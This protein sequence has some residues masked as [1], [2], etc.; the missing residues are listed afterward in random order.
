MKNKMKIISIA[1]AAAIMLS[2]IPGTALASAGQYVSFLV[3][4]TLVYDTVYDFT[5]GLARVSRDNKYGYADKTGNIVI[6]LDYEWAT[7]FNDGIAWVM[8]DEKWGIIDKTGKQIVGY[9]YDGY[10]GFNN[11]LCVVMKGSWYDGDALYGAIDKTGKVVIPVEYEWINWFSSSGVTVARKNG[12]EGVIDTTGKVIVPFEYDWIEF[13]YD[14]FEFL[15]AVKN[16]KYGTIDGTGKEII[17]FAYEYISWFSEDG[18][19]V[20]QLGEY[21]TAKYGIIDKTG[22]ITVWLDGY[23][24]IGNNLSE[25]LLAVGNDDDKYGFINTSGQVVI[26]PQYS[27]ISWFSDGYAR[28]ATGD[29]WPFKWGIIDKTGKEIIPLIYD[30]IYGFYYGNELA[31]VELDG[32][33]GLLNK[34]GTLVLPAIYEW[35][36]LYHDFGT[37]FIDEKHGLI[38]KAGK[39]IIQPEYEWIDGWNNV[40][41]VIIMGKDKKSGLMEYATGKV[42]MQPGIYDYLWWIG[43]SFAVGVTGQWPNDKYGM[44]NKAGETVLP[45]EYDYIGYFSEDLAWVQKDG[46]WGIIQPSNTPLAAGPLDGAANWALRDLEPALAA[47]LLLESMYGKWAQTTNRLLAAEAIV[48][49]IEDISGSTIDEIAAEKGFD[50]TDT[51]ADTSDK[52]ATFLKAAEISNGMDGVNYGINENFTRIQMVVMLGRIAEKIFDMDLS[53]FET[54]SDAFNDL[55]NW[56]VTTGQ[57]KYVNWAKAAGVTDGTG[58]GQFSPNRLLQNQETGIFAYRAFGY[59]TK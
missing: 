32:R 59:F 18:Y 1:L 36:N 33:Y 56:L 28:V 27:D 13:I 30:W 8:K 55:P 45:A 58:A 46:K 42:V 15:L 31:E 9:E 2:L 54:G 37:I 26:P 49:L 25:G 16:D 41:G 11:G 23:K 22:K 50:L 3:Q 5:E 39:V 57:D 35:V 7:G 43:N 47:G 4:P 17:P 12:L 20:I 38:D 51:F 14:D 48:K 34:S 52:N 44:V 6:P 24:Y 19:A 10:I 21:F 29:E 53:E 40:D